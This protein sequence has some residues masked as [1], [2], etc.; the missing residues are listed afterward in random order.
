MPVPPQP[1]IKTKAIAKRIPALFF[2]EPFGVTN[3]KPS[4]ANAGN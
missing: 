4:M 1:S 2:P 3:N